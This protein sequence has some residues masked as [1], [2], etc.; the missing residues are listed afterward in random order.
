[1]LIMFYAIIGQGYAVWKLRRAL[2]PAPAAFMIGGLLGTGV[3][4]LRVAPVSRCASASASS[5]SP[6]ASTAC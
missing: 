2:K 3:E 1:M 6:S 5:W 4:L